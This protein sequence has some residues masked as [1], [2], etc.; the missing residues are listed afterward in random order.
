MSISISVQRSRVSSSCDREPKCAGNREGIMTNRP[1]TKQ[2]NREGR[3]APH[4]DFPSKRAPLVHGTRYSEALETFSGE[5]FAPFAL[6]PRRIFYSKQSRLAHTRD[7]PAQKRSEAVETPLHGALREVAK[8]GL[9][10]P[11]NAGCRGQHEK[12]CPVAPHLSKGCDFNA[13]WCRATEAQGHTDVI[14]TVL[15]NVSASP[16]VEW[17]NGVAEGC[18]DGSGRSDRSSQD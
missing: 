1:H 13:K 4:S 14:N 3:A 11:D 9:Q 15:G 5:R 7:R 18:G 2:R 6:S 8:V 10:R 17:A 12:R 16:V